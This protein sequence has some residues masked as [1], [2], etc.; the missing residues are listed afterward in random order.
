MSDLHPYPRSQSGLQ[1]KS[2]DMPVLVIPGLV[3]PGLLH[4]TEALEV[5]LSALFRR[6]KSNSTALHTSASS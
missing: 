6:V 5:G 1:S 4:K 3:I 2:G